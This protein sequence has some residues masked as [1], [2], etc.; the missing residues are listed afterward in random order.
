MNSK[1]S[2]NSKNEFDEFIEQMVQNSKNKFKSRK[3][4][5]CQKSFGIPEDQ[6][7]YFSLIYKLKVF[8]VKDIEIY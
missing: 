5:R 4:F 8:Q 7:L 1:N 2:S 6:E 3:I